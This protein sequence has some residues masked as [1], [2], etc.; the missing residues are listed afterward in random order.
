MPISTRDQPRLPMLA[1]ESATTLA[2]KLRAREI[3]SVE[4]LDYFIARGEKYGSAVNAIVVRDLDKARERAASAD[5]AI[6]RGEIWGPLHGVPMTIKESFHLAGT[7]TTFGFPPFRNNI[8]TSNAVVVDRLLEAGAVIFGKSNVPPGLM[9]GQS[10][11]E[12]YGRTNNPWDLSRTPGGSSGGAAA[13][14]AAGLTGLELGSD[15]ASS[16]R[17]PA[18]FCGVFGHKPTF[19][20]CP[21]RG[22]ML[23]EQLHSTDIGVVGPLARSAR[24][25]ETALSIIAGPDDDFPGPT[26]I[27]RPRSRRDSLREFRVA[28]VLDDSFAEVDRSVQACLDGLG[29]FLE[30]E[31]ASVDRR[32]RPGFDSER[33]YMLYMMLL[34]AATSPAASN[35]EFLEGATHARG[36]TSDTRDAAK[37]NAFGLTLS[38]RD[39]I[40]LDEERQRIRQQWQVFFERFDV[41]LCPVLSSAAFPHSTV[42]PQQRTLSVNGKEVRFENQLLWAGYGGVAHLPATVAPIG[43]TSEGLPIGAQII[44]PYA[45]DYTCLHFARLLEEQ[46]RGFVPPPAF[47]RD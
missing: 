46:Y 43:Q 1:F 35:E 38:H 26:V 39:W 15:I 27:A 21:Q 17:N 22:H 45:E 14:L 13:A 23:T 18:H 6:A 34:R 2:A 28:L 47:R 37:A 33:L 3:G 5:Q 44:G 25:L 40:R 10:W 20:L 29:K 7:P 19:G 16:I 9:D 11:N 8:A 32:A 31:G 12:I 42:H 41:L 4:L 30:K 36:V 24:D